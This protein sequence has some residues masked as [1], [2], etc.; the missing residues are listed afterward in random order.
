MYRPFSNPWSIPGGTAPT[1]EQKANSLIGQP[2]GISLKNGQGISG[3]LCSTDATQVFVLQ[4]LYAFQ[5]ATFHYSY[6]DIADILPY[7]PCQG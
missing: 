3:V 6:Q 1:I 5:F 4:Y 2:V 7:P